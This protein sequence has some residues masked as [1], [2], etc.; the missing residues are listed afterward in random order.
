MNIR[1]V[2]NRQSPA[3]KG[4][5]IATVL[6]IAGFSLWCQLSPG[7]PRGATTA[8]YT[9]DDGQTTFVDDFFRGYPFDVDGKPAVRAYM[10]RTAKGRLFVGYL[11]RY[12][13][14]GLKALGPVLSMNVSRERI[15]AG[16]ED[17]AERYTE[18]KKP[19]DPNAKWYPS[20]SARGASVVE[21]V[22]SPDGPD[23]VFGMVFP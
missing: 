12:T 16:M 22:T 18:V 6:L 14:A 19:N 7:K 2:L 9:T 15:R 1:E 11:E 10:F 4:T 13:D 17:V 3:M 21:G 5:I 23:D 8:Y 20:G